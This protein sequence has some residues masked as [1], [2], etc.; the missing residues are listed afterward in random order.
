MSEV[1]EKYRQKWPICFKHYLVLLENFAMLAVKWN[2]KPRVHSQ[3]E[4]LFGHHSKS[5][6]IIILFERIKSYE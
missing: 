5:V 4:R 1:G 3:G 2:E 6:F